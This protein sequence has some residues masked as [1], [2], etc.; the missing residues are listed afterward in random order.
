MA[1]ADIRFDWRWLRGPVLVR[2][3]SPLDERECFHRLLRG[4][5]CEPLAT[6]NDEVAGV[7]A[8]QSASLHRRHVH[9]PFSRAVDAEAYVDVS[10]ISSQHGTS[11]DCLCFIGGPTLVYMS[12]PFIVAVGVFGWVLWDGF[13]DPSLWFG[14]IAPI[15]YG[16]FAANAFKSQAAGDVR[17]VLS[18]L[19]RLLA[20]QQVGGE[21]AA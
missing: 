19:T 11:L 18:F 12:L 17:F 10:L 21:V 9:P 6:D 4:V 13:A 7:V 1:T 5:H 16:G 15:V 20:V 14:V 2:L 3:A 8:T